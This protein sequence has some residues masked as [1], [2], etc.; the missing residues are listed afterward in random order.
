MSVK[1]AG[2]EEKGQSDD[3]LSTRDPFWEGG[4]GRE[5]SLFSNSPRNRSRAGKGTRLAV[6]ATLEWKLAMRRIG[7]LSRRNIGCGLN[8]V[9]ASQ[10]GQL[11]TVLAR[12]RRRDPLT[13]A[14][15]DFYGARVWSIRR[16][17]R[18]T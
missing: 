7:R 1:G 10:S 6:R 4:A 3:R 8:R 13:P 18:R 16:I 17:G 5:M 14:V 2:G 9:G 15:R 11:S 12:R